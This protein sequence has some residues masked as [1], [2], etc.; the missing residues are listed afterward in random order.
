MQ[1][2]YEMRIELGS[3]TLVLD[4]WGN[5]FINGLSLYVGEL[6][7]SPSKDE[8][9]W[10]NQPPDDPWVPLTPIPEPATAII[11]ALGSMLLRRKN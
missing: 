5:G 3:D 2:V 6:H 10:D 8:L 9:Y 1:N 11:F 4:E 7:A